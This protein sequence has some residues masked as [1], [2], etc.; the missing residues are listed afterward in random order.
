VADCCTWAI[1]GRRVEDHGVI[2]YDHHA[3]RPSKERPDIDE[4][5]QA[6]GQKMQPARFQRVGGDWHEQ[7]GNTKSVDANKRSGL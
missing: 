3:R 7:D 1:Q 4:K 2:G 6:G 5:W